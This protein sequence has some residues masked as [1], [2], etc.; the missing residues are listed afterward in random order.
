[1]LINQ[2]RI[3]WTV[4]VLGLLASCS[5]VQAP[6]KAV[7]DSRPLRS[8]SLAVISGSYRSGDLLLAELVTRQLG[9]GN[10]FRVLSQQDIA[11][12]I[13][14]YPSVIDMQDSGQ[15]A[16]NDDRATWFSSAGKAKLDAM[17]ARL[18]VDYVLVMWVPKISRETPVSLKGGIFFH[19]YPVGNLIEYPAGKV[20]ASTR[21]HAGESLVWFTTRSKSS[22]E[23][24]ENLIDEAAEKI[25]ASLNDTSARNR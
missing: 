16:E 25:G 15:I 22:G 18:G 17:Q 1:M 6:M 21:M 5:G 19:V 11:R 9:N 20:L 7:D 24:I 13:P 8:G 12:L 10:R 4:F 23:R 14:E 3:T 2:L